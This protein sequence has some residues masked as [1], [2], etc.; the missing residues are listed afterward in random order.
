MTAAVTEHLLTVNGL[1]LV[2]D[3]HGSGPVV[4]LAHGMWCEAGMFAALAR[5]L[6][7]DHRV[8]VP[9]LRGHGRSAVPEG[10]WRIADLADDLRGILDALGVPRVLLAGF[11]MGG[12]A[13]VDFALRVPER[14][15]GL[16]L[17]G[18][19]AADEEWVRTVE[20][21]ALAAVL[22]RAGKPRL[23][24]REAARSTF[25]AG[26]R[27]AHPDEVRRWEHAIE[28]MG[29]DALVAALQAVGGR[30]NLLERLDEIRVP[31][32][33][34]TGS[35][36]RILSPRWSRAMARRLPRARL[37]AWHGVGHAIPMERPAEVAAWIRGLETGQ[38]PGDG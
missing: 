11:S 31:A 34:L 28:A 12:M 24:G 37:V 9:D 4:M 14:L 22:R 7:R 26:F 18:T 8:L 19:S 13:A 17:M 32:L 15:T 20:I 16:V 35:E 30:P 6:A 33:I 36:D 23:L 5:D 25:S 1:E 27:K 10:P 38:Y 3:D 21:R 2:V 29:R